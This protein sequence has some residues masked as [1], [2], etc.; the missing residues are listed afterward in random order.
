MEKEVTNSEEGI[1]AVDEFVRT[2]NVY[3]FFTSFYNFS[4]A[5]KIDFTGTYTGPLVVPRVVSDSGFLDLVDSES[6]ID[7]NL[8]ASYNFKVNKSFRM[9]LS[10]K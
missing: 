9:E 8:K 3:G 5:F 2:P 1:V 6:F 4:K 10:R 7:V